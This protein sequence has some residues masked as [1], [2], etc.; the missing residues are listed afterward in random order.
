[1]NSVNLIGRLTANPEL[2][3]TDND[4][5]V[6]NFT[7]AVD[8]S[9][10]AQGQERQVDFINIVAWRKTAEF[11][12]KYFKKGVRMG[13]TGS[14]QSRHY[15]DKEGNDRVVYEVLADNVCFCESKKR[16]EAPQDFEEIPVDEI[17]EE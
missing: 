2:R 10:V 16:E 15:T 6:T 4:V 8:R 11:V 7:I 1:M 14:L 12:Y 9:F 5:S 13:V 17:V 3:K